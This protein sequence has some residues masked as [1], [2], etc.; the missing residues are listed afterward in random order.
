MDVQAFALFPLMGCSLAPQ[1][2]LW[3]DVRLDC[4][5]TRSGTREFTA[6]RAG[7]SPETDFHITLLD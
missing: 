3:P 1:R 7:S 2:H 4:A 5:S 6:S